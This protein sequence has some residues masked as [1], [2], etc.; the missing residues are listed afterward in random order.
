MD[1]RHVVVDC[2]VKKS[3]TLELSANLSSL[4][5]SESNL[6]RFQCLIQES[7]VVRKISLDMERQAEIVQHRSR[8]CVAVVCPRKIRRDDQQGSAVDK[9]S[10][11]RLALSLSR[12]WAVGRPSECHWRLATKLSLSTADGNSFDETQCLLESCAC[13]W[14]VSSLYHCN[15]LVAEDDSFGIRVRH[16]SWVLGGYLNIGKVSTRN[17]WKNRRVLGGYLNIGKVSTRNRWKNR[18]LGV[19]DTLNASL[20]S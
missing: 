13:T 1:H 17:R 10:R 19:N 5:K 6:V 16:R 12:K 9:G 3:I 14:V 2:N 20:R 7:R 18:R 15:S 11:K 8:L 4:A